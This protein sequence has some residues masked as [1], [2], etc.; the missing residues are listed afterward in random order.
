M[1]RWRK[2]WEAIKSAG[3]EDGFTSRQSQTQ[4]VSHFPRTAI[5]TPMEEYIKQNYAEAA[6]KIVTH[7]KDHKHILHAPNGKIT[8]LTPVQWL[9]V[10]LQSFKAWFGD[11][12]NDP[13]NASKVVDENGEATE[14][15]IE[16]ALSNFMPENIV[17][18]A[19]AYDNNDWVGRLWDV[20]EVDFVKTPDDAVAVNPE[21]VDAVRVDED[22]VDTGDTASFSLASQR[23]IIDSLR[24]SGEYDVFYKVVDRLAKN[25]KPSGNQEDLS[26]AYAKVSARLRNDVLRISNGEIDLAKGEHVVSVSHLWHSYYEHCL[27]YFAEDSQLNLTHDDLRMIPDIVMNYDSVKV[28]KH[29]NGYKLEF[30]KKYGDV[31]Y[32]V[33]EDVESK[34]KNPRGAMQKTIYVRD[35]TKSASDGAF[36]PTTSSK[37]YTRT[38]IVNPISAY[39]KQNY[40]S[41]AKKIARAMR[42]SKRGLVAPNGKPSKLSPEQWLAVR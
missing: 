29:N 18:S 8:N 32:F 6:K 1:L 25:G 16:D 24:N 14:A 19:Q 22:W 27:D 28:G 5:V 23:N 9:A 15:A 33:V 35:I 41:E 11:W 40:A 31:E 34:R 30:T 21:A 3:V 42:A 17:D 26:E 2:S 39:I 13:A 38:E 36:H 7:A 20:L 12:E 10:R 4:G 37:G